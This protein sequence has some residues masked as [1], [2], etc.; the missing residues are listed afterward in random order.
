LALTSVYYASLNNAVIA[1]L[2]ARGIRHVEAQLGSTYSLPRLATEYADSFVFFEAV[3]ISAILLV[4]I[5]RFRGLSKPRQD[6]QQ[7]ALMLLQ[8]YAMTGVACFFLSVVSYFQLIHH[9]H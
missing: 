3:L 5:R 8:I 4:L 6:W 7:A 2:A 9:R 1:L